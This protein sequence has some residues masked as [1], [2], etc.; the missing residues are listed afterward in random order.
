MD[1]EVTRFLPRLKLWV[2]ALPPYESGGAEHHVLNSFVDLHEESETDVLGHY[3]VVIYEDGN[4]S[5][6]QKQLDD[7]P[8]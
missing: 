6:Q 8:K 2:S 1:S 3:G 5:I 4:V 7:Y